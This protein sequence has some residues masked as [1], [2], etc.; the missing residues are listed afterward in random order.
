MKSHKPSLRSVIVRQQAWASALA[1]GLVLIALLVVADVLSLHLRTQSL[2]RQ[3]RLISA[4]D[5]E[6]LPAVGITTTAGGDESIGYM[7]L[8]AHGRWTI[9]K[10]SIRST[11]RW[12]EAPR[13]LTEG[14][15]AGQSRLPWVDGPVVWA[16]RTMFDPDGGRLVLVAWSRVGAIRASTTVMTFAVITAAIL[17]AFLI[18]LWL[19]LRTARFITRVLQDI[20]ASS[21]RMAGGDYAVVLPPQPTRELDAVST[22]VT[23]LASDLAHATADLRAEHERLQQLEGAQ[24]R[25]VADASHELRT[26]LTSMRCT[27]EAWQDDVL[28]AEERPRAVAHLLSETGRLAALTTHLLDLSRIESGR[29]VVQTEPTSVVAVAMRVA[30]A[31]AAGGAPVRV[32]IPDDLP[33]V[34][35]D[36]TALHRV[37]VN[38]VENARR[39]TP[40]TGSIR[41]SAVQDH[42]WVRIAVVDTGSGIA[43]NF[44][45]HIWDRFARDADARAQGA[46]GSGLG[47]AIVLALVEAMGG[48]V[49]AESTPGVQTTVWVRLPLALDDVCDE[50]LHSPRSDVEVIEKL[51]Q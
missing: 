16:A 25:F 27:L 18:S 11:A 48:D 51:A 46:S 36:P 20:T 26:P 44:L 3:L 23:S 17:L 40:A 30:E 5:I 41:I 33:C 22:A 37:L 24:R 19:N 42:A 39:F 34:Q 38:L 8:D 14:E 7:L 43:P 21:M 2:E 32:E 13:V 47:L 28:R 15:A 31:G 29:E 49:G 12:A 45:P 50:E 9:G 6:A 10:K 4:I 1:L 35:A